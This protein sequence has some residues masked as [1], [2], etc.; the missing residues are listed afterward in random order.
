M[1]TLFK[2]SNPSIPYAF[3][4]GGTE[5][6]NPLMSECGRFSVSPEY[7]GFT[8]WQTGGGCT[9]HGQTFMLD[10]KPVV[11][12]LTDGDLNQVDSDTIT[13]TVGL[14]DENIEDAIAN[15]WEINR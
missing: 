10:G 1:K 2:S 3:E 14:Y 5:I 7:Y 12:L 8:V 6:E 13:A 15:S 4:F 9:A 11:M